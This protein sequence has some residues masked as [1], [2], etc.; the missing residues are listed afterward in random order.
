[1]LEFTTKNVLK[2][3]GELVEEYRS[4]YRDEWVLRRKLFN[5][6][7]ELRG[8]SCACVSEYE[9]ALSSCSSLV[10]SLVR[11]ICRI[12]PLLGDERTRGVEDVFAYPHDG[13]VQL[14]DSKRLKSNKFEFDHVLGPAS[15]QENVFD[16]VEPL[17][18]SVLDGFNVC[19][20]AYGE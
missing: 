1:M 4:R 14:T 17:V 20:F 2:S 18:T 16:L 5:L 6:V 9:V 10:R 13:E 12:R 7:Q 8:N 15:T 3:C 11:V 19:I